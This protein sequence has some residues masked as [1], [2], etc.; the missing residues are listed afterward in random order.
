MAVEGNLEPQYSYVAPPAPPVRSILGAD[1]GSVHTRVVFIDQVDGQYRLISR[2]QSLTTADPPFGDVTIGLIR[3][4]DQITALIGRNFM[5][6]KQIAIGTGMVGVGADQFFATA[7]GGRPMRVVLVGLMPDV[8]LASGKNALGSVYIDL[9]DTLGIGDLRTEEQQVNTI[10]NKRPDLIL[11]VGGTDNGA[12]GTM[13]TLLKTV[14]LAISLLPMGAR[15]VV[16]YAGN[17]ALQDEVEALLG[18]QVQLFTARNVRPTL[19]SERLAGAQLELAV[20]YGTYKAN[21][22]GYTDILNLSKLGLLPS[23]NSAVNIVRYLGELPGAGLGVVSVDVGASTV[24]LCASIRK[25][26]TISIRSDLGL[27]QSAVSSVQRVGIPNITRWLTYKATDNEVLDYAFNKTLRPATVPAD[28]PEL[29]MELAIAREL[30]RDA[31]AEARQSWP[32]F[33]KGVLLPPLNPII[34]AGAVLTEAL[35]PGMSAMVLLDALQPSGVTRIRLDPYGVIAA[36]GAAVYLTPLAAVQVLDSGGL[37]DLGT[38]LSPEGQTRDNDAMEITVKYGGGRTVKRIVPNNS[39]RL[40]DLGGGETAQITV[41][42]ARGLTI[43]GKRRLTL[44]VEGGAAGII[45]DTRGRPLRLPTDLAR[46]K[47]MMNRWYAG[48]RNLSALPGATASDKAEPQ[49]QGA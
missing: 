16:L 21:V 3:A 35:E 28:M 39:F 29:E 26:P 43:N 46:R 40:I 49:S 8:S 9:V 47:E 34:G 7:S 23:A 37:L 32:G 2:A 10:L 38:A 25:R 12:T 22:G 33:S 18:E 27:G 44:E 24:T 20:A 41:K 19:E 45:C 15:P 5:S 30:V 14:A 11:V 17:E 36:L 31:L 1:F 48:A 42:L 13:R 4:L 6:N